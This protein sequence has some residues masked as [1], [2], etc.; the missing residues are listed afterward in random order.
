MATPDQILAV[1]GALNARDQFRERLRAVAGYRKSLRFQA[2]PTDPTDQEVKM[3]IHQILTP[4]G[5]CSFPNLQKPRAIVEGAD[6]RYSLTIIFDKAAQ[7][8]PEFANLQKGIDDALRERWPNKL[9]TGLISPF[10]DGAEKAGQYEGYKAGDIFISPWTKQ[11]PGCV[12]NRRED[13]IDWSEF[14]AG[15]IVRANV[16]PFAYDTAGKRGCSF[17]LET[18]QFLKPG[19]RLDGRK[20]AN[21]SFPEDDEGEEEP[22]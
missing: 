15:W 7:K 8:R 3:A 19:P 18:V 17:F 11:K 10:H 4:P 9:P 16:R 1:L 5:V 2:D 12:N 14:Y 22:V 6:E 20:P 13:I 21:Q